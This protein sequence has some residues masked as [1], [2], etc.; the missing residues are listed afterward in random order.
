MT[1]PVLDLSNLINVSVL[2]EAAG[3][4]NPDI[5]TAALFSKDTAPV[6]WGSAVYGVYKTAN[7]VA[8]DFGTTSNAYAIAA[9]WFAQNPN[10]LG[11]G[12][13]LVIIPRLTSPSLETAEA[14]L[15]RTSGL[16]YY[17]AILLDEEMGSEPSVFASFAVAVK[18]AN[19]I[20]GYCSSNIA[21]IQPGSML[22][23]IRSTSNRNVRCFYHGNALLNGAGVQQTQIFAAAYLGRALST[24]FTGAN[25]AAT[26]HM[27]QLSGISPDA[28]ITQTQIALADTAGIVVYSNFGGLVGVFEKSGEND[29]FDNVY[30]DMWLAF[31]LQVAGANYLA[32]AR[33]KIPQTETGMTG[34]KNALMQ[35]LR[36]A[37]TSGLVAPGTWTSADIIGT[38]ATIF[39]SNIERIGFYLWTQPVSQQLAADRAARKAPI[40]QIGAKR[41][42]AVHSSNIVVYMNA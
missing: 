17:A 29:Y 20:L 41:A 16:I 31:A 1:S 10:C 7:D 13:Y 12:G 24:D 11:T 32:G 35:V 26:M 4:Q 14:A 33:T 27:K 38:D 36:Q 28:T 42:G 21:D 39:H 18:A 34:Y 23:L 5:N 37:V 15:A 40:C 8:T 2:P 25:T 9:A 6:G 22:D 19:K 3:L 30:G